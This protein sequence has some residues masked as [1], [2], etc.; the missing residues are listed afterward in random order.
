MEI[1]KVKLWPQL[2]NIKFINQFKMGSTCN[3]PV[4][5]L[6]DMMKINYTI[7]MFTEGGGRGGDATPVELL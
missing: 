4:T 2:L 5:S 7:Y 1:V 3:R 6:F